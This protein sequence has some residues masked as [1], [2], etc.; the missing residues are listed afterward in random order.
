MAESVWHASNFPLHVL[1]KGNRE[2]LPG[3]PHQQ[4]GRDEQVFQYHRIEQLEGGRK[5]GGREERIMSTLITEE[6]QL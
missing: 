6:I 2:G 3:W 4:E 5:E 1:H